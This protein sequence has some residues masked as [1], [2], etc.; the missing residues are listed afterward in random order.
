MNLPRSI[1]QKLDS[2]DTIATLPNIAT[3][4]LE[5]MRKE[6]SSMREIARVI[7]QDPSITAK[8]L[9]VANSPLWGYSGRVENIQRALV[10]M[11]L[12][13]VSNIVIAIS[14]YSTFAKLK[15]NPFF[16]R[17]KF[18]LHSVGTAQIARKLS[19]QLKVNFY[20]EEFVAG[21]LHD[22]GKMLLDQFWGEEFKKLIEQAR[23][24]SNRIL[25][26]E[27]QEFG[28]TH[29]EI[30]AYLLQKWNFPKPI[31]NVVHFHHTPSRANAD[32]ELIGLI[33]LSEMLCELWGV[34]FDEDIKS[35]S[36]S[37]NWS[38]KLFKSRFP[39]Q[40]RNFDVERFLF[41]MEKEMENAQLFI[42]LVKD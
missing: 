16:D 18:W 21:L 40:L 9:K 2:I 28:C 14:L 29:A 19:K 41:E 1:A 8:I 4:I 15:P 31:V 30:G 7:E 39:E 5:I 23:A 36:L 6:T 33:S 11:G 17:K 3:E 25:V 34:G 26:K 10:L 35:T 37:N 24:E 32:Q 42:E 22:L 12:K 20:G 38:W 13:Q 27:R